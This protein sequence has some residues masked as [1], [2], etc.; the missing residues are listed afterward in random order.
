MHSVIDRPA[1]SAAGKG[2]G[3]HLRRLLVLA[4][5]G[6]VTLAVPV[7]ATADSVIETR[8]PF[9]MVF[10]NPCT[11]EAF[12]AQ[13]F[14]HTVA[15]F[16]VGADGSMHDQYH[17][18]ME[19]VTAKTLTGVKYVVQEEWNV[20][21]NARDEHSTIH[22]VFKQHFV[23]ARED[24]SFALGDD[25]SIYFRLHLTVNAQGTPTAFRLESE[26]EPCH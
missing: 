7:A 6:V 26:E 8:T 1:G 25:F 20:G 4:T 24:G 13:G 15:R 22:H 2:A 9:T 21:T 11:G 17:L 23:R 5:I 12:V 3:M 19:G 14:I 10:E 16:T 18:N